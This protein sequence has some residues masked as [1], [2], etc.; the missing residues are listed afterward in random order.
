MLLSFLISL[1]NNKL[2]KMKALIKIEYEIYEIKERERRSRAAYNFFLKEN[3]NRTH[4]YRRS[5]AII[6]YFERFCV[7]A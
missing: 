5:I 4:E 1:K 7:Y 6:I 2:E 3:S